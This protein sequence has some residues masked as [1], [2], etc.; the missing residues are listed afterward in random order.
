MAAY[1][2]VALRQR[3]RVG[4]HHAYILERRLRVGAQAVLETQDVFARDLRA[5]A[6]EQ[7]VVLVEAAREGVLDRH[8]AVIA[9]PARYPLENPLERF[10]R[11]RLDPFT[12]I[13]ARR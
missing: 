3:L 12:E 8:H 9:P 13:C 1:E 6:H 10:A 11:H 2:A 5:V 7:T 4:R